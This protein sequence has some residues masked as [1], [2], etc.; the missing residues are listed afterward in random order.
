MPSSRYVLVNINCGLVTCSARFALFTAVVCSNITPPPPCAIIAQTDKTQN[1][2][3]DKNLTLDLQGGAPQ[4]H[5]AGY[6]EGQASIRPKLLP[7]QGLPLELR[8]LPPGML[9]FIPI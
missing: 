2:N 6:Q 5:Q 4:P 1:M 8:C 9:I 7:P 3:T